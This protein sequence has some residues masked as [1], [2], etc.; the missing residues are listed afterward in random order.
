M[1]A[2]GQELLHGGAAHAR[3]AQWGGGEQSLH[4]RDQGQ[5]EDAEEDRR[6]HQGVGGQGLTDLDLARGGVGGL[7]FGAPKTRQTGQ[8]VGAEAER[9]QG[10]GQQKSRR[11]RPGQAD[12][13]IGGHLSRH[14]AEDLAGGV[15]LGAGDGL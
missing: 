15:F 3:A 6:L 4:R 10:Q 8:P 14:D 5:Q 12:V 9:D 13:A 7:P 11:R 1:Q 2:V